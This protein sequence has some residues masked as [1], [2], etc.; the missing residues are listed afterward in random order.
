MKS[1][2]HSISRTAAL[3]CAVALAFAAAGCTTTVRQVNDTRPVLRNSAPSTM[4]ELRIADTALES[5]NLDLA[6]SLYEKAVQAD[7]KSVPGL[8]GLG[9]TLYAVGDYTRANVY[10]QRASQSDPNATAPLIGSARVAIHQRRF[11]DAIATYRRVLAITPNDPLS[12]A[13]LG[14][15]LDLSGDH[16]QAQAVLRDA[17]RANPGD[18]MIS[19][20]LGLSLTL[21]GDP[22]QGANV[23]LD[24]T[25]F[26]AA[27][28]QARQNLALAYGLLGNED[29]AAAILSHDLP[30]SSVQDN[31]RYYEIQRARVGQT[32]AALPAKHVAVSTVASPKVQTA[33]VK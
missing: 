30:K 8:T 24:V 23:L 5:N 15:A 6:T 22:R 11:D 4:S 16:A 33:S 26:P 13:G 17:L 20:N 32:A 18:P 3:A 21:G 2:V 31:L 7:P 19:V 9:N 12:L 14:A 28:P 25:R 10:Y 27:P 29:A 1:P